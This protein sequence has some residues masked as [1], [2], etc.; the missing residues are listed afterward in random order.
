MSIFVVLSS[1][2]LI[3]KAPQL[4][5]KK[6]PQSPATTYTTHEASDADVQS[7]VL[8]DAELTAVLRDTQLTAQSDSGTF[9]DPNEDLISFDEPKDDS[10]KA[11]TSQQPQP[12]QDCL[13]FP[14]LGGLSLNAPTSNKWVSGAWA[15]PNPKPAAAPVNFP[16]LGNPSLNAP[17][18]DKW[19]K[20]ASMPI[21]D[22]PPPINKAWTSKPSIANV[23]NTKP[24]TPAILSPRGSKQ[25][26]RANANSTPPPTKSRVAVGPAN[27]A[28]ANM[29]ATAQ[30]PAKK[31]EWHP[32]DPDRPG[33]DA[34]PFYHSYLRKYK[35]P[36]RLCT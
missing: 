26:P 31:I 35:C 30:A 32:F 27:I 36:Y 3:I 24:V 15:K 6:S 25:P 33:F 9:F 34:T 5:A 21:K 4:Q 1:L 12:A 28:L 19:V 18:N 7:N 29:N 10:T 13:N 17:T 22:A 20:N 2:L 23:N 14:T 16:A 11:P 8:D